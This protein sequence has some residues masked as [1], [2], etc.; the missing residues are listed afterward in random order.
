MC[1]YGVKHTYEVQCTCFVSLKSQSRFWWKWHKMRC[2]SLS[3]STAVVLIVFVMQTMQIC[4]LLKIGDEKT[5]ECTQT[6]TNTVWAYLVHFYSKMSFWVALYSHTHTH[7]TM[8][9]SPSPLH[10]RQ[11]IW[12]K[13]T[14]IFRAQSTNWLTVAEN[15][16]SQSRCVYD[17]N[18]KQW[19][20]A[21]HWEQ[22]KR[23]NTRQ[24][25]PPVTTSRK[26]FH[27]CV[28]FRFTLCLPYSHVFH[29]VHVLAFTPF[30][31]F[32][33]TSFFSF[34]QFAVASFFLSLPL[35]ATELPLVCCLLRVCCCYLLFPAG[36]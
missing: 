5:P 19:T 1:V 6:N 7:I 3:S 22:M 28:I 14:I 16:H 21:E 23:R 12:K 32:F 30:S 4:C 2:Q 15:T 31:S 8:T 29:S 35:F 25:P 33:F 17:D 9:R 26:P 20:H 27:V 13:A 36:A 24:I 10:Q 18:A 11:R 34:A